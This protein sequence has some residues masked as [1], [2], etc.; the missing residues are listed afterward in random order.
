MRFLVDAQLPPALAQL[1]NEHGHTAEHVFDIGPGD[2]SDRELWQYALDNKSVIVTKGEDFSQMVAIH[3]LSPAVVWVRVGNTR[4]TA[5]LSWFEPLIEQIV[6][7]VER[8]DK[9][10]ELR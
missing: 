2:A 3:D 4:R 8:G 6:L 10:I 9:V 5:L 1:L 7:M